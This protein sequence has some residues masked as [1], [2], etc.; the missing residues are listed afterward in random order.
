[1][2]GRAAVD[3][4]VRLGWTVHATSRKVHTQASPL[5]QWHVVDLLDPAAVASMLAALRCRYL[6]HLAWIT[7][8]P[9]YWTSPLNLD[10]V[11]ASAQ[12]LKDFAAS[13]GQRVVF[14]G[15]CA[16]YDWSDGRLAEGTTPL[17]PATPYGRSK[18]AL[19]LLAEDWSAARGISFS[20]GRVF[21]AFGPH[22]H[23]T[24]LVAAVTRSLLAGRPIECTSCN[25]VRDLLYAGDVGAAFVRVLDSRAEGALNVCSGT[26]VRL[27]DVVT[28]IG[29]QIGRPDLIRLGALRERPNE[30]EQLVG[31]ATRLRATGWQPA[32]SLRDAV[33]ETVRWWRAQPASAFA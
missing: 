14:A 19:S 30:P 17:H 13:G 12:L 3:A 28:E 8:P 4:L 1:M 31:D 18:L 33:R 21:F 26:G 24:R 15:T 25:Q 7:E 6:L 2:I 16:E 9:D 22:E 32:W 10:W 29:A 27:A 23:P 20:W 11:T 5:I